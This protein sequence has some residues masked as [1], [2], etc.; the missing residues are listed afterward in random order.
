MA[1][2]VDFDGILLYAKP[3]KDN[4]LL[5]KFLT[6]QFGKKMFLVRGARKPQFKLRAAI[7][8]FSYGL[9]SGDIKTEGLSYLR[10]GK[11]VKNFEAISTDIIKNAYATYI[12]S[13]FDLAFHD[14]QRQSE[15]YIRILKGLSLINDGFDPQ[16]IANIF[17]IQLLKAFGVQ[18][19]WRNCVVCHRTDLPFDYSEAYGGLLCAN[20]WNL[21]KYRM[22]L[23]QKT[24]YLLRLFS[25]VDL[26]KLNT[27]NVS[28]TT[29][30]KLRNVID[31]IYNRSVGV[32]PKSKRFID[33]LDK[34]KI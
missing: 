10:D 22:H 29:K 31:Q 2:I 6:K 1:T 8:P 11:R 27:I 12:M 19:D 32:V 3:Y 25:N 4:D 33:Q 7:L 5:I 13:L 26:N 28:K 16:I 15:W 30:Q 34:Y 24:I 23:D 21:D 14:G 17:E 20:H 9:Y 18:P